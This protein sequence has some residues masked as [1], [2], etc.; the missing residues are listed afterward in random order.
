MDNW[1]LAHE[2]ITNGYKGFERY[3]PI[4]KRGIFL[5]TA[6]LFILVCGHYDKIKNTKLIENFASNIGQD[7]R[8][9]LYDYEYLL[10]FLNS[11]DKSKVPLYITPHVFTEFIKHLTEIVKDPKQFGDILN[12]SFKPKGYLKE[13]VYENLLNNF[14]TEED[15][16]N[17]TLEVGDISI[18]LC[19]RKEKQKNGAIT[20]LT[21]DKPFALLS[22]NKHKF[23][24]IYYSEIRAAT[25]QIGRKQI[26]KEYL[27]E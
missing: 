26:P 7:S 13:I 14:L 3:Y 24:T 12:T 15:F 27:V 2:H 20:I 21:D 5:D 23:I 9:K 4:L 10:A 11:V 8:Y 1:F 17:K 22:C 16:L 6:P 19:A 18:L 25:F